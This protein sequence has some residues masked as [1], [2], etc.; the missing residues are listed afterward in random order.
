MPN[1][2]RFIVLYNPTH[3]APHADVNQAHR[4]QIVDLHLA[5]VCTSYTTLGI[6]QRE[7]DKYNEQGFSNEY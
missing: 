7:A 2:K 6:A 1:D 4:F 3:N 5:Q